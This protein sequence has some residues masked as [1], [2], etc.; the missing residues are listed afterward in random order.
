MSNFVVNLSES[1]FL[2]SL[3][4]Q[5]SF[6]I[7]I[8]IFVF[9]GLKRKYPASTWLLLS[10]SICFFLIVGSKISSFGFLSIKHLLS[11]GENVGPTGKSAF[12]AALIGLLCIYLIKR[13]LK[14][15]QPILFAFAFALP[16]L[17][18]FQR[19]GCF[20]AGC[21]FG[22]ETELP[23]GIRYNGLG[24]LRDFQIDSGIIDPNQLISASVHP[25][26]LYLIVGSVIT[27]IILFTFRKRYE[28]SNRLIYLSFTCL[29]VSRFVTEFFRNPISNNGLGSTFM[30]LNI[31]QWV[32]IPFL[33]IALFRLLNSTNEQKVDF[34]TIPENTNRNLLLILLL[35]TSIY[36][37]RSWFDSEEI[38][39]LHLQ[40]IVAGFFVILSLKRTSWVLAHRL[41]YLCI[42]PVTLLLM[43]QTYPQLNDT[44]S[45]KPRIAVK[46][47]ISVNHL[48]KERYPAKTISQGCMGGYIIDERDMK[49]PMGPIYSSFRVS[50][51]AFNPIGRRTDFLIGASGEYENYYNN[52]MSFN[53]NRGNLHLY[54]GVIGKKYFGFQGGMRM[55][56]MFRDIAV[57]GGN[58]SLI[59]TMQVWFGDKDLIILRARINDSEFIG[60]GPSYFEG[61]LSICISSPNLVNKSYLNFGLGEY[62]SDDLYMFI[63]P[64]ISYKSMR[65]SPIFGYTA[66]YD[67]GFNASFGLQF[68][69]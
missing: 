48:G 17:V 53:E 6:T 11:H 25:V 67:G 34:K 40:I 13:F 64:N 31:V 2:Y 26:P 37:L 52:K 42:F 15:Q 4:Y 1:G 21:C 16:V 14:F 57:V 8:G 61:N 10:A 29:A 7:G 58:S 18:L 20:F 60:A 66:A 19:V 49:K 30:G 27:L 47:N 39:V 62:Y 32:I 54:A 24:Y 38:A 56:S 65:F 51:E 23:W 46:S 33:A 36:L 3:F 44:S 69:F 41:A 22:N 9:E 50:A 12:G 43:A 28:S 63:G 5:L 45:Y 55:G 35:A 68:N 59:G